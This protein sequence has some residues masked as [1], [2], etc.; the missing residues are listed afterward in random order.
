MMG[1]I[2]SREFSELHEF[3]V[4][5]N[6]F[7]GHRYMDTTG[8]RLLNPLLR[9]RAWG[10]YMDTPQRRLLNPLLRKRAQGNQQYWPYSAGEVG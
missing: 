9:M 2:Q 6:I 10:K 1:A 3:S 8:E 7:L 4:D 5:F